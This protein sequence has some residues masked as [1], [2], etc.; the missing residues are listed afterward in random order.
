M[1]RLLVM[2][3]LVVIWVCSLIKGIPI[4]SHLD[5]SFFTHLGRL[6]FLPYSDF[7]LQQVTDVKPCSQLSVVTI[8]I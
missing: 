8:G 2:L 3:L 5:S 7:L 4:I 6:W 1:V